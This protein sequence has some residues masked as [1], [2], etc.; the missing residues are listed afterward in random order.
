MRKTPEENSSNFLN[1]NF[2]D[3]SFAAIDSNQKLK[4]KK[5]NFLIPLKPK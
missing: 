5:K 1:A 2:S 3:S 4:L